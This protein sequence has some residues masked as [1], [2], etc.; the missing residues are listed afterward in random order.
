MTVAV[1]GLAYKPFSHITEE[2]QAIMIVK[3]LLEQGARVLAYDPLAA[4]RA[5]FEL[6]GRALI[7]DNARDCLRE[8]DIVLITTPD[9]EFKRLSALDFQRAGNSVVVVDFWRLLSA[10]LD[11]AAG[12][13]YMPYG[14]GPAAATSTLEQLWG[15][16][17]THYGS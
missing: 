14:R 6:G 1:L 16:T 9:P 17:P 3:A 4:E 8:A 7:L 11:G 13:Q 10:E 5:G 15:E 12:I 2:S